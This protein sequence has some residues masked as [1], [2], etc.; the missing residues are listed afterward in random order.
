MD[1]PGE[2]G[3]AVWD[4]AG[5]VDRA[6]REPVGG[7]R[8]RRGQGQRLLRRQQLGDRAQPR[9]QALGFFAPTIWA[10]LNAADLDL[11]S[12]QPVMV[13]GGGAFIVGKSAVGYLLNATHLGGIGGQLA[14]APV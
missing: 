1:D 8:G 10:A 2:Q 9:A 11:G 12:T 6:W 5:P 14:Q 4:T 13:P 3:G 7:R